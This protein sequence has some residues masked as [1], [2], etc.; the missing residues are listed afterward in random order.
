MSKQRCTSGGDVSSCRNSS[1][2]HPG[3][4][5]CDGDI[6]PG[7]GR[8]LAMGMEAYN[9]NNSSKNNDKP[10]L[11]DWKWGLRQQEDVEHKFRARTLDNKQ[12]W[13]SSQAQTRCQTRTHAHSCCSRAE[14]DRHCRRV[15]CSCSSRLSRQWGNWQSERGADKMH[16]RQTCGVVG[17][18][19]ELCLGQSSLAGAGLRGCP[20]APAR[21]NT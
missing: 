16:D 1:K 2:K 19:W 4:K 14:R 3:F 9:N 6:K 20:P 10:T 8:G 11:L 21:P 15:P 13:G 12:Q 18:K 5:L 7:C 17:P